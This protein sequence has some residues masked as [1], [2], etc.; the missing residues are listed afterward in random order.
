MSTR[1]ARLRLVAGA[2]A[3]LALAGVVLAPAR[4]SRPNLVESVLGR[5]V[6]TLRD[7]VTD[8]RAVAGEQAKLLG[9]A[10]EQV[11]GSALKGYSASLP[12]ALLS[13]LLGDARVLSVEPDARVSL[14]AVQVNPPGGLDRIDQRALP[15]SGSYVYS[16]G[17]GGVRAYVIDTG[18][19]ANHPEFMGRV[20]T[21]FNVLN[22]STDTSD[23][24]GHGTHVAGILGSSTYGVAKAATIVPVK[25][26]GCD[27]TSSLSAII[28]GIDWATA[29]HKV[30]QPAVANLSFNAG[31]SSALDRA[32]LALSND[33]VAVAA[34][35]GNDTGDACASSPGRVAQVLTVAAS[36]AADAMAPFS[37]GGR[38]IDLFAPGV[39]V[40]STD[41]RSNGARLL[42]GTSMAAPHVAGA[43]AIEMGRPLTTAATAQNRLLGRVTTGVLTDTGRR[44]VLLG[45]CRPPTP[46]NRLL[47]IG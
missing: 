1:G 9:G 41:S 14:S 30:G 18:V 31:A 28:A 39:G 21:G 34:A 27:G 20:T 5:Y 36:D 6:V 46:A 22:R 17:G 43:L 29:D 42:S 2:V 10:V 32:V 11:F 38:C 8:P 25:A 4:A 3:V 16:T 19:K 24:Y 15:L 37:N 44:C 7:T 12:G 23:C 40:L 35:A 45:G 33:G 47:F 13:R 26:F